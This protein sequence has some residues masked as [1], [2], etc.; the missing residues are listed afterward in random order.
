MQNYMAGVSGTPWQQQNVQT[1]QGKSDLM[2][3]VGMG[4][5]LGGGGMSGGM[6]KPTA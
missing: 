5:G 4:V 1:G 2:N 3:L 6:F